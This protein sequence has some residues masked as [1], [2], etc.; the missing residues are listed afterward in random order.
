MLTYAISVNFDELM[1]VLLRKQ[2]TLGRITCVVFECC[3]FHIFPSCAIVRNMGFLSQKDTC[4]ENFP[5]SILAKFS[6][7][8]L[9]AEIHFYPCPLSLASERSTDLELLFS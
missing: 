4:R 5:V 1:L 3:V 6:Q 8:K 9:H 7:A 2:E